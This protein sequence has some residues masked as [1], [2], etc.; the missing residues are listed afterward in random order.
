MSAELEISLIPVLIAGNNHLPHG[1][2]VC[3]GDTWVYPSASGKQ[4]TYRAT[5]L[6]KEPDGVLLSTILNGQVDSFAG[7]L[8][9]WKDLFQNG[10]L[11]HRPTE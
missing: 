8:T 6:V 7:M 10:W 3:L 4:W 11:L 9:T 1:S 2:K 5:K